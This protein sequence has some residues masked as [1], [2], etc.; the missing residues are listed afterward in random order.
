MTNDSPNI[1]F[2]FTFFNFHADETKTNIFPPH[3]NQ[4]ISPQKRHRSNTSSESG[5][6]VTPHPA[7]KANRA[8]SRH[9]LLSHRQPRPLH[10][11]LCHAPRATHLNATTGL[12]RP[13]S[14][15]PLSLP[16]W[17]CL[18]QV[19]DCSPTLP[20]DLATLIPLYPLI[21]HLGYFYVKSLD[22]LQWTLREVL[23]LKSF[24][25]VFGCL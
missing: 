17:C 19:L 8:C 14:V 12:H 6:G 5:P 23:A 15:L 9:P 16:F 1:F 25:P 13:D 22:I 2:Y 4:C 11:R 18:I 7:D 24:Y 10:P 21:G 20:S 3:E